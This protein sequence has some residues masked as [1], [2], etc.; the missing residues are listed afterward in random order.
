MKKEI[1]AKPERVTELWPGELDIFSWI[2]FVAAI[3]TPLLVVTGWK[4]NGKENACLQSWATFVS[5]AGE[6]VCI[7]GHASKKGHMYQSLKE[8]GCCVLNFPSADIFDK[9]HKTIGNNQFDTDEI[10]ASGLTAENAVR[11]DAP[12][13]AECFLNIECE[14]LWEQSNFEN[15]NNTVI[16]LKAVHISMDSDRYDHNV[17]GRYGKNGYIY[18]IHSPRNPD[19][20]EVVEE[21]IGIIEI[22]DE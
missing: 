4:S 6:F 22:H 16:A 17:L 3:P 2:D 9:C 11:I 1:S 15:S 12:R 13:I 18:N 8:T 7:L 5:D 20:G 14:F 21:G 19:T 10:T